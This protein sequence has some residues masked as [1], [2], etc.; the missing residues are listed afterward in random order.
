M[1][2]TRI[3]NPAA[4]IFTSWTTPQNKKKETPT[5]ILYSDINIYR[6]KFLK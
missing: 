3:E 1:T 5:H 4:L 6:Y 2:V